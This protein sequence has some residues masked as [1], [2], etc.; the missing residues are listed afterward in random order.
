MR[1]QV[2]LSKGCSRGLTF[3]FR[4]IYQNPWISSNCLNTVAYWWCSIFG[5]L[6]RYL[7]TVN[8]YGL[9]LIQFGSIITQGAGKIGGQIIQRGTHGQT[10][11]NLTPPKIRRSPAS[12]VPRA[13]VSAVSSFW[14]NLS[15]SDRASW[16][17][18]AAGLT[19][20]QTNSECLILLQH[21]RYFVSSQ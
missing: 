10:M 21:I 15:D 5:Y 3:K 4:H 13:T 1:N 8:H 18:L 19:R 7:Y 12:V 17:A 16:V 20:S 11:R 6:S 14:K 9:M 2:F